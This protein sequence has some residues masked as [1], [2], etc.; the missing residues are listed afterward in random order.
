VGDWRFPWRDNC[1]NPWGKESKQT[2][3]IHATTHTR[4]L[5]TEEDQRSRPCNSAALIKV[6]ALTSLPNREASCL[7]PSRAM[8]NRFM[9]WVTTGLVWHQLCVFLSISW[10][11]QSGD[12]DPQEDLVKF[13]YKLKMKVIFNYLKKILLYIFAIATL[14]KVHKNMAILFLLKIGSNYYG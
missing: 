2:L 4:T 9:T 14:N 12:D 7:A 6:P 3:F 1:Q 11:T 10:C 13:G 8:K 5:Q